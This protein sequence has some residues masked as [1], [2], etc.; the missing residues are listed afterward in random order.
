MGFPDGKLSFAT[1]NAG[2]Y[3]IYLF[4]KK[5]GNSL[6]GAFTLTLPIDVCYFSVR[7][8]QLA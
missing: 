4:T 2:T 1:S 3:N 6:N 5:S 8:D 7:V